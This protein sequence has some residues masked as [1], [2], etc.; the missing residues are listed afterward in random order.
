MKA[1]AEKKG[2]MNQKR[3]CL[4]GSMYGEKIMVISPKQ[5]WNSY[6]VLVSLHNPS[7]GRR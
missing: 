4:N 5:P 2:I 3:E 7:T 1:Y 6:T